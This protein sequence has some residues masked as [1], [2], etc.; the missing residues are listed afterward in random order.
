MPA[1]PSEAAKDEK[2][3]RAWGL[4]AAVEH[5]EAAAKYTPGARHCMGIAVTAKW[6][7]IYYMGR[8]CDAHT[9]EQAM[10]DGRTATC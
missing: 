7:H 6:L 4:A 3:W 10:G 1:W 9:A 8:A 2:R 5:L